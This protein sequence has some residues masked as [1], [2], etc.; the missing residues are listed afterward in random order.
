MNEINAA[1]NWT[2]LDQSLTRLAQRHNL[3]DRE[4]PLWSHDIA[5]VDPNLASRASK[6][7]AW[8]EWNADKM[9]QA[10]ALAAVDHQDPLQAYQELSNQL[11]E[12]QKRS[13]KENQK[14]GFFDNFHLSWGRKPQSALLTMNELL[15][16]RKALS[17][18][19]RQRLN[20][21]RQ[22]L[23]I[24]LELS[25][26]CALLAQPLSGVIE[27]LEEARQENNQQLSE[28]K[29]GEDFV[30]YQELMIK[31]RALTRG[32]DAILGLRSQI[33]S[34]M[35]VGSVQSEMMER[36]LDQE[37]TA[38][39]RLEFNLEESLA[40]LATLQGIQTSR[41]SELAAH[42]WSE[43]LI[44]QKAS[45][46]LLS[47]MTGE[48]KKRSWKV[49]L[50]FTK[51][52]ASNSFLD[53]LELWQ[54]EELINLLFL[55]VIPGK[56][57][58]TLKSFSVSDLSLQEALQNISPESVLPTGETIYQ[59]LEFLSNSPPGNYVLPE[60]LDNRIRALQLA[61][62][63]DHPHLLSLA[64]S[65]T[66]WET[67]I[68]NRYILYATRPDFAIESDHLSQMDAFKVNQTAWSNLMEQA[69]LFPEKVIISEE[70]AIKQARFVCSNY[71]VYNKMHAHIQSMGGKAKKHYRVS[72][73]AESFRDLMGNWDCSLSSAPFANYFPQDQESEMWEAASR[74]WAQSGQLQSWDVYKSITHLL[75]NQGR[76]EDIGQVLK[77]FEEVN[78]TLVSENQEEQA[79]LDVA[80]NQLIEN[81]LNYQNVAEV[82]PTM[83]N[84]KIGDQIKNHP[85]IESV[86]LLMYDVYERSRVSWKALQQLIQQE[87]FPVLWAIAKSIQFEIP[88]ELEVNPLN[89]LIK[90]TTHT[91]TRDFSGLSSLSKFATLKDASGQNSW[92]VA[93]EHS[94]EMLS[95]L[96][97]I[98]GDFQER[99]RFPEFFKILS[100]SQNEKVLS[101]LASIVKS[102][103]L[104]TQGLNI[105][106]WADVAGF[107]SSQNPL[108]DYK[109]PISEEFDHWQF[110]NRM[111]FRNPQKEITLLK[112]IFFDRNFSLRKS[113][114]KF[115]AP[116][117]ELMSKIMVFV[118]PSLDIEEC[119]KEL[120]VDFKEQKFVG[121]NQFS[122]DT[123]SFKDIIE[124]RRNTMEMQS[125][126]DKEMIRIVL[127]A[128]KKI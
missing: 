24:R 106:D 4:A 23:D 117:V 112:N 86:N 91:E 55:H 12:L 50:P 42:E 25:M 104:E 110:N 68:E 66:A 67:I 19:A 70:D 111:L 74:I 1:I 46:N 125:E 121:K 47:A 127:S 113:E 6:V 126:G 80:K 16:K 98:T 2:K 71:T 15:Q 10:N 77:N 45:G 44:E 92:D 105:K 88:K 128:G 102:K 79:L 48:E 5:L 60:G 81:L 94:S 29:E 37:Q 96:F 14:K 93:I 97:L 89:E 84:S 43:A 109:Y 28:L 120:T 52:K 99:K 85:K 17:E 51:N 118:D 56:D 116:H 64:N 32:L 13:V 72:Y 27:K 76:V 119:K 36:A 57:G 90:R 40:Q 103:D 124:Y 3:P 49:S 123:K 95:Q 114:D 59:R 65:R 87:Q 20:G 62:V 22:G 107:I 63:V 82:W 54:K 58:N 31:N 41:Q 34:E 30:R 53:V 61:Y 83:L 38:Q 122:D 115:L 35:H 26:S 33:E 69:Q 8:L 18:G 75:K 21:L 78:V 108:P 100:K 9:G 73:W 39:N 101:N 11:V 7:I